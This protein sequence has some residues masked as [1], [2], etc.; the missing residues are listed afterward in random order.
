MALDHLDGGIS[1]L[2]R[3]PG[4]QPT[5]DFSTENI[6]VDVIASPRELAEGGKQLSKV[7]AL[8]VQSFG[9]EVVFPY[10][11]RF[12]K[13]CIIEGVKALPA[14]RMYIFCSVCNLV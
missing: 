6:T 1:L 11:K 10:L 14:P 7:L 9:H 5:G 12:T 8:M 3:C 13:R 4:F 2:L